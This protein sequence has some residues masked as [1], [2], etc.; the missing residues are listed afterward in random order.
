MTKTSFLWASAAVC[1]HAAACWETPP[2]CSRAACS[3][4]G[5]G[6][7]QARGRRRKRPYLHPMDQPAGL[8][9]PSRRQRAIGALAPKPSGGLGNLTQAGTR[10]GAQRV[11]DKVYRYIKGIRIRGMASTIALAVNIRA[12]KTAQLPHPAQHPPPEPI[13][14]SQTLPCSRRHHPAEEPR[15][16]PRIHAMVLWP[17]RQ[18][19][20]RLRHAAV[21]ERVLS[22]CLGHRGG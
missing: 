12:G 1:S 22:Q 8:F 14:H 21:L 5:Q 6:P 3:C 17:R 15:C 18:R 4:T 7:A 16:R 11:Y 2:P 9:V 10:R 13:G 19:H 20:C